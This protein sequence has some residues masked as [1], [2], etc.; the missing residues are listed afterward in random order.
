MPVYFYT[1]WINVLLCNLDTQAVKYGSVW[2]PI[3]LAYEGSTV[4]ILCNTISLP[5]WKLNGSQLYSNNSKF[6]G[7][8]LILNNVQQ[9]NTGTYL[10]RGTKTFNRPFE[11]IAEVLIGGLLC[12]I[13]ICCLFYSIS[14]QVHYTFDW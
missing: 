1:H 4:R 10:C 9:S 13:S 5:K 6:E 11:S 12:L 14:K 7:Y 2:P 8:Y 3:Q